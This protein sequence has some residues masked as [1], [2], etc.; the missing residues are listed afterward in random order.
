[1]VITHM[2]IPLV[3]G[4]FRDPCVRPITIVTQQ[5]QVFAQVA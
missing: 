3:F 4:P 5:G 2:V 1:M